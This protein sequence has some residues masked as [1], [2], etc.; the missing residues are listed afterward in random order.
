MS[1]AKQQEEV[2]V[3]VLREPDFE[4]AISVMRMLTPREREVLLYKLY[5]L[6]HSAIASA[7]YITERTSKNHMTNVK[8]KVDSILP[9]SVGDW[10]SWARESGLRELLCAD[11]FITIPGLPPTVNHAYGQNGNRRFLTSTALHFQSQVRLAA[12]K[13]GLKESIKDPVALRIHM[14]DRRPLSWDTDNRVKITQDALTKAGIWED[15]VLVYDLHASK[16]HGEPSTVIVVYTPPE[17]R[18]VAS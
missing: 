4:R 7:L 9:V 2:E 17:I 6:P 13:A 15:D 11:L 14:T 18:R 8:A 5:E 12:I 3:L 1:L 10:M 16:S